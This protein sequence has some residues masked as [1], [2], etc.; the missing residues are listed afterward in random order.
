MGKFLHQGLGESTGSPGQPQL[1]RPGARALSPLRSAEGPISGLEGGVRG[2]CPLQDIGGRAPEAAPSL[3]PL[4][5]HR[6]PASEFLPQRPR[7]LGCGRQ[8]Q[9]KNP[10][11]GTQAPAWHD[12]PHLPPAPAL[13]Q[14]NLPRPRLHPAVRPRVPDSPPAQPG[15]APSPQKRCVDFAVISHPDGS[16]QRASAQ[17]LAPRV[18]RPAFPKAP[19]SLGSSGSLATLTYP[20]QRRRRRLR[21]NRRLNRRPAPRLRLRLLRVPTGAS[22]EPKAQARR[23]LKGTPRPL[24]PNG[25]EQVGGRA[26]QEKEQPRGREED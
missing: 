7:E 4:G 9:A 22:G 19:R 10:A 11:R 6:T 1:C 23:G 26:G 8:R 16:R 25:L 5:C 21:L 24:L 14:Q 17:L 18:A 3:H 12:P 15:A 13:A 20:S 2:Q